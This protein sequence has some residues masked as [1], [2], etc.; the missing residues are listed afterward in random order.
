[1]SSTS[2]MSLKEWVKSG[3]GGGEGIR[4]VGK[5]H[6]VFKNRAL[7]PLGW[8]KGGS[9]CGRYSIKDRQKADRGE[10]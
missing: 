3:W 5:A 1:M 10:F 7:P 6:Q 2:E 4:I 9:R 8:S